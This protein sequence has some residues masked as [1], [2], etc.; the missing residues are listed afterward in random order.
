MGYFSAD[1]LK[2]FNE[3]C[4]DGIDFAEETPYDF[5]R[6][7]AP[8]GEFY[9]TDGQCKTGKPVAEKEKKSPADLRK[10]MA[11]YESK[12]GNP[13]PKKLVASTANRI[14]VPIPDGMG[15]EQFLKTLL[16]KGEKVV[17]IQPIKSA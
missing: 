16:P 14:G 13:M 5:A 9:G 17:P 2:K 1:T 6:C 8:S 10:I 11:A 7:V 12:T 15:A 4:A 3:M